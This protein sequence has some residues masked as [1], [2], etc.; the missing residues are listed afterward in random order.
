MKVQGNETYFVLFQPAG[1][2]GR[3]AAGTTLLA[4]AQQL[5]IGIESICG[6]Q[7]VCG[8][9]KVLVETGTFSRDGITSSLEHLTPPD[10]AEQKFLRRRGWEA[11]ARLSCAA[12]VTGDLVITVPPES[13]LHK[14]VIVK[15]ATRLQVLTD[16]SLRLAYVALPE[17][18]LGGCQSLWQQV[19]EALADHF[20][21]R[22]LQADVAALRQLPGIA[23]KSKRRFTALVWDNEE[24]IGFFP[25]YREKVYGLAVDVGSTTIAM[26][27]SDL[28][29]GRLLATVSMM[30]PQ[31]SFGEDLM[32]RV[33]YVMNHE[34][35]LQKLQ[36]AVLSGV[37]GL[38]LR[39][40]AEAGVKA[41]EI[42]EI[43]MVGNSVIHHTFLGLDPTSLGQAPFQ[44]VLRE[45]VT[46]KAR[47]LGLRTLMPGAYAYVPPLEGGHVGAD[48]VAVLLAAAPHRQEAMT[49]VLDVG[50]NGEIVLGNRERLLSASSPTGPAFEGAAVTHGMRATTGA[51]ERVRIDP[52]TLAVRFKVIGDDHWSDEILLPAE[53]ICGTGVIEAMAELFVSGILRAD[54]RFDSHSSSDRL[55]KNGR[56]YEFVLAR[57]EETVGGREIVITQNDVRAIQLAKAALYAGANLLMKKMGVTGVEKVQ[58]AGAF[59]TVIDPRHALIIGLFPDCPLVNVESIGNAAGDGARLALLDRKKKV[60]AEALARRV[61]YVEIAL[62]DEF[63]NAFVEAMRFP[64]LTHPMPN[65]WA[66]INAWR[67]GRRAV[68][69]E[70]EHQL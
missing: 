65:A 50:T 52:R 9:C 68:S 36:E 33:S 29:N 13:T 11:N 39:A 8:K 17:E 35:G 53:G 61:E 7:Q 67:E 64:H 27:L 32:S 4:A 31:V 41:A 70:H 51:I 10:E 54:G 6:G 62:E 34:D 26:Y 19:Q 47:D 40:T 59:G 18:P 25:G 2:R 46:L 28:E 66:L 56:V 37:D 23:A 63:Q 15:E 43:V 24:V 5:G 44:P 42:G 58:L 55:R 20:G 22:H 16:P 48:N 69:T 60:E 30:N 49:L 38:A 21:L 12:R 3:V 45:A 1:K 57:P 14:Q